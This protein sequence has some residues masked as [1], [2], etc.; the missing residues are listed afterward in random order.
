MDFA[1]PTGKSKSMTCNYTASD[2][3]ITCLCIVYYLIL[4]TVL[5]AIYSFRYSHYTVPELVVIVLR[6]VH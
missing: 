5:S 4:V 2:P 6:S 3:M 1:S